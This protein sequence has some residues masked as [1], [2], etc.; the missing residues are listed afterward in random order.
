MEKI[1]KNL[2]NPSNTQVL[3]REQ[4][5][6]VTGG[7]LK[8]EPYDT[9]LCSCG[10]G[11]AQSVYGLTDHEVRD[12]FDDSHCTDIVVCYPYHPGAVD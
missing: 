12:N 5:K 9:A 10:P 7:L 2:A 3:S 8:E 4:M 1:R 11:T 6:K